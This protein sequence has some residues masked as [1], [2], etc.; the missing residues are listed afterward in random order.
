MSI[1]FINI[2]LAL[3]FTKC[4]PAI[5]YSTAIYSEAFAI[6]I[7]LHYT[8][9]RQSNVRLAQRSRHSNCADKVLLA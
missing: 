3:A 7:V 5:L 6:T 9:N 2:L 4:A 8:R 1:T